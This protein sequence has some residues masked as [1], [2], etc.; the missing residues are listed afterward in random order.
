MNKE[1]ALKQLKEVCGTL[2]QYGVN[3]WVDGG[4]LLGIVREQRLL[5]WDDDIDLSIKC[6]DLTKLENLRHVFHKKGYSVS[7]FFVGRI[8]ND[9]E[10]ELNLALYQAFFAAD[11]CGIMTWLENGSL[12]G[13]IRDKKLLSNADRV[14]V[15]ML[16]PNDNALDNFIIIMEKEGF[17]ASRIYVFY[18]EKRLLKSLVFSKNDAILEIVLAHPFG[19]KIIEFTDKLPIIIPAT[20][21]EST[22][23]I[24]SN[25][26]RFYVP[27]HTESYLRFRYKAWE[28]PISVKWVNSIEPGFR[29]NYLTKLNKEGITTDLITKFYTN[30]KYV[31]I[32]PNYARVYPSFFYDKTEMVQFDNTSHPVPALYKDYLTYI[33]GHWET[34][35]KK[36]N[37]VTHVSEAV[38]PVE[39]AIKLLTN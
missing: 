7:K 29:L 1:N 15:G 25:G 27:K 20:L 12:L 24:K 38:V 8:N 14:Y 39:E 30:N 6:N 4:T 37:N 36:W 5:P 16:I 2:A 23:Q 19:N 17:L 21:L 35:V 13:I 3:Y 11:S 26:L 22:I 32:N 31:E 18:H 34:P 33:Y 9:K 10:K 28:K